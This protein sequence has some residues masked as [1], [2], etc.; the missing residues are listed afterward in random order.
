M[1]RVY[2]Y[3]EARTDRLGLRN[4]YRV[5]RR[6]GHDRNAVRFW[7]MERLMERGK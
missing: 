3:D 4:A 5:L 2:L 1:I 7:V 6:N